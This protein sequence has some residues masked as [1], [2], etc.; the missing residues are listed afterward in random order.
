MTTFANCLNGVRKEKKRKEKERKKKK[1]EKK[2]KGKRAKPDFQLSALVSWVER[3][4]I[5]S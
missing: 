4:A 3:E 2:K 1:T 5:H